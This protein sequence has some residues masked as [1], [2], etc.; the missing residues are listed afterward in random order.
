M[1]GVGKLLYR[2]DVYS[3][4]PPT[5][6]NDTS[7]QINLEIVTESRLHDAALHAG[8]SRQRSLFDSISSGCACCQ[9]IF[10]ENGPVDFVHEVVNLNFKK[11]IGFKELEGLRISDVFAGFNTSNP[12]FFER[13]ER[14]TQ[15]GIAERFRYYI[16]ELKKWFDI[17]IYSQSKERFV[18]LLNPV[19][20]V[21]T[22]IW[23][24][25][26]ESGAMVWSDELRML[27][28]LDQLTSEP[29]YELWLKSILPSD[30]VHS[31]Q[32]IR[33]AIAKGIK[34]SVVCR[35]QCRDGIIRR[36]MHQGF[37]AKGS[38]GIE[39]RY[40]IS[41]SDITEY[42]DLTAPIN[43]INFDMLLNSSLDPCCFLVLDGT[44]RH[45]NK[46]FNDIYAK[47]GEILTGQNF[48]KRFPCNLS[49]ERKAKF[50]R[51]FYTGE[52]IY[53]KDRC[54]GRNNTSMECGECFYQIA[55]YPVYGR[56]DEIESVAVVIT[57]SNELNKS[58]EA[59]KQLDQKYQ[60]LIAASP[61]S[62]I[63]TNL[64]G[65]ITSISDM[66][67]GLY[68]TNDSSELI[69]TPFSSLVH[70]GDINIFNKILEI[71]LCDGLIQNREIL[72]KKKNKTIYSA[73]ISAALIQ[74]YNGAP[75]SYMIIIRDIS[76]RKIIESELF[77]AKRLIS[78]GEMASGIAH[79]I[80]Q[81][82]NNIGL[83][84]DKLLMDAANNNWQCE[85]VIRVKSDKIFENIL[86]VQTI[87]DNI[88]SF[89]ST[90]NN[91]ISSVI[92]IN[93]S[94]RNAL[95][96]FSEQCKHK[97]ILLDFKAKY[98]NLLVTGNMYNFEQVILNLIKNSIDALEE[99]KRCS[100]S[101]FE[102]KILVE[103]MCD[104]DWVIVS[105]EDNGIGISPE[106]IEYIMHPFYTTKESGKGTGLGL[107]IS[108][109][110]IKEMNGDIKIKSTLM[111][112]T[113]V[114]ITLPIKK[115]Q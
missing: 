4:N 103:S 29:S 108:Y 9:M 90:D 54:L 35:V 14:V 98:D 8:R 97:S 45:T 92:S 55:V 115:K 43:K 49:E 7:E 87:I 69:G 63:T 32:E 30:R 13:L 25:N 93:K 1:S 60:T 83:I 31:E 76:Q 65:T 107:S 36:L 102:M 80:Y 10:E 71:A 47:D 81:P 53:Y 91:Y 41:C 112:G 19:N 111:K 78:L 15:R 20:T 38:G 11:M 33:V 3:Y 106:N 6:Q 86:R 24:W 77:H 59:Q 18:L 89:S 109:G 61:D 79:E 73:E 22:G 101:D 48:H 28:G 104:Q 34:F 96:M 74:D 99:K 16:N 57:N 51:V 17:S 85:K 88:R 67:I 70:S 56:Y 12:E 27:F 2:T 42:E 64:Q 82:I 72:L 66:G 114:I 52:S 105:V 110:I 23:E 26:L 39:N 40:I 58:E 95:L 100:D 94:I 50:D 37:P 84:V 113:C 62:I 68:G 21:N 44:I 46:Y 75:S 5:M